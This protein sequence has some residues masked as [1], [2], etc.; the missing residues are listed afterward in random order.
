MARGA[1]IDMGLS[2]RR[3]GLMASYAF[4]QVRL[5]SGGSSYVPESGA[6][7]RMRL[8]V[9]ALPRPTL[10]TRVALTAV[11]G[12]RG[13]PID[14]GFEWEANNLLDLG[15]EFGGSPTY[16]PADL[17]ATAL[18]AY[19][20]LD[21]GVRKQWRARFGGYRPNLALFGTASNLLG[22]KNVLT[23]ARDPSSGRLTEIEMRPLSP[24]VVGLDWSF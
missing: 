23:Y 24:L 19:Y 22:R 8:G 13:T 15:P 1:S 12:R 14:G 17:G 21:L 9:T 2:A 5:S 11:L 18:P 16:A 3:L 6:A 10:T 20:R 7:H 4:D